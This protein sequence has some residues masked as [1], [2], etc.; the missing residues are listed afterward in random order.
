M[1]YTPCTEGV[2]NPPEAPLVIGFVLSH[3]GDSSKTNMAMEVTQVLLSAQSVDST[4]RNHAEE[5]LK[6][7]QEQNL[8]NFLLSLSGEL[9]S[10]EKPAESRKLAGLILKNTLDAKEQ[11]RK[12]ELVQRW[13]SLDVALKS[14]CYDTEIHHNPA[15]KPEK[16]SNKPET[17][18]SGKTTSV[19]VVN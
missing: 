4:V 17:S 16:N 1:E 5:T 3:T 19:D 8:P 18:N 13:L 14:Q 10:E 12:Y 9:S 15:S 6:Q 7:I 11:R 2:Y